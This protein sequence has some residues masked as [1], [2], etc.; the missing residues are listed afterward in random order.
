MTPFEQFIDYHYTHC[1]AWEIDTHTDHAVWFANRMRLDVEQ[2]C[3][4]AFLIGCCEWTSVAMLLF[5][6]F[7]HYRAWSEAD[8]REFCAGKKFNRVF[9]YE[10]RWIYYKLPEVFKSYRDL[11]ER[12]GRGRQI[13]AVRACATGATP[14]ERFANF[15]KRFK[16]KMFGAYANL[17]YTEVLRFL[18]GID[19]LPTISVDDNYSVRSG[20]MYA[21]GVHEA[22]DCHTRG[23]KP[24][25]EQH[26]LLTKGLGDIVRAVAKLDLIPRFKTIWAIE[27]SLCTYNKFLHGKRWMGYYKLRQIREMRNVMDTTK[28]LNYR[29]RPNA[30]IHAEYLRRWGD[31]GNVYR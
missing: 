30:A 9:A 24:T 26:D 27:T 14:E 13:D 4:L 21:L 3:W 28:K 17:D 10:Y 5:A 25:R 29:W 8:V 22:F 18:C 20:L 11:V 12:Y 2:R 1:K 31:W 19:F 6:R 15:C 7:P 23:T 16:V